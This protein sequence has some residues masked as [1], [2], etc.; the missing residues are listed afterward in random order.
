[1]SDGEDSKNSPAAPR[2]QTLKAE[3][4]EEEKAR[5]PETKAEARRGE[6]MIETKW[7]GWKRANKKA[8][9][10]Q[11]CCEMEFLRLRTEWGGGELRQDSF[12]VSYSSCLFRLYTT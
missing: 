7:G 8:L 1:M 4:L 9:L 12:E 10:D 11:I 3:A 5:R 6:I 2:T